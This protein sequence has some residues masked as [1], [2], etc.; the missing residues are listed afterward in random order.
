MEDLYDPWEV[1]EDH[2]N[3]WEVEVQVVEAHQSPHK[4]VGDHLDIQEVE[5]GLPS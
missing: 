1:V 4:A 5:K 3:P 2:H